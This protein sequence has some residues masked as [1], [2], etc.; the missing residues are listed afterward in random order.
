MP[1]QTVFHCRQ[2]NMPA[3]VVIIQVDRHWKSEWCF[4]NGF[5][6]NNNTNGIFGYF[7]VQPGY[8]QILACQI[9]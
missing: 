6:N 3:K 7:C 2:G 8:L 1:D 4:N 9:P 5:A